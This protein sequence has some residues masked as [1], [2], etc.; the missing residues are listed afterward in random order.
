MCP[1]DV[2]IIFYSGNIEKWI[3]EGSIE[4]KVTRVQMLGPPG[5]G[6][7]CSQHLL[8]NEDPPLSKPVLPSNSA[9]S[10]SVT[11]ST[12]IAC[13]AVKSTRISS[14]G[15]KA[16]KRISRDELLEKLASSLNDEAE[17]QNRKYSAQTQQ[18]AGT[19][20]GKSKQELGASAIKKNEGNLGKQESRASAGNRDKG[21]QEQAASAI[22]KNLNPFPVLPSQ[23]E[24]EVKTSGVL[25][26]IIE[27]IPVA[28]AQL[29]D[30]WVYIIDSGGQPAFQELLPLFTR[31]ASLNVITLDISKPLDEECD[32]QYRING[33]SFHCDQKL[34]Y[35][36]CKHFKSTIL[37]G[38]I[39]QKLNLP[40]VIEHPEHSMYFVLGTHYD[41]FERAHPDEV[42]ISLAEMNKELMS[43]LPLHVIN[44]YI[45]H[46]VP[47]E[48]I[49]FPVNALLPANSEDRKEASKSLSK[50]ISK[51]PEVSLKLQVPIRWFVFELQ[52]EERAES[53]GLSF[54]TKEEAIAEGKRL[55]MNED[56]VE[57]ALQYLHNCTIILYYPEVK[58]QLVFVD[59]QILLDVLSHLLA[60][61]YIDD[62]EALSLVPTMEQKERHALISGK[63]KEG[64][65]KKFTV[66][67]GEFQPGYFIN[68]LEHLHIIAELRHDTYFLPCALPAHDTCSFQI[69]KTTIKPLRLVW[70]VKED[71]L[72]SKVIVPVPRG[73]FHLAIV[74]LLKIKK[75]TVICFNNS[76]GVKQFRDVVSLLISVTKDC[77]P[78]D[79]LYIINCNEYIE[80]CYTGSEEHCPKVHELVKTA[81]AESVSALSASCGDLHS[82]FACQRDNTLCCFVNEDDDGTLKSTFCDGHKC[83]LDNTYLC[84]FKMSIAKENKNTGKL[85]K[86]IYS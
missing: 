33:Q 82:A 45:I 12:P 52:L 22:S 83:A 51:R 75:S 38:T 20:A 1:A 34:K 16:L 48:S 27:L 30:E 40:C 42:E 25:D 85:L 37:S 80:V 2:T 53:K 70:R 66:F 72:E 18:L 71:D 61:T 8:L 3:G 28:K 84:W 39:G 73:S 67:S 36:N 74:H 79:N 7:T 46:N 44:K 69:P 10:K 15:G 49:I 14:N 19:S 68:L 9:P 60:L 62:Q 23:I 63:F 24:E 31:A 81:I 77:E 35:T 76:K 55:L 78:N 21:K 4:L 43:S 54:V 26:E 6:K 59:P 17:K 86:I 41:E 29:T 64:F 47:Q 5:S 50:A 58:P 13:K 57:E 11:N 56:A 65:L 32:Y